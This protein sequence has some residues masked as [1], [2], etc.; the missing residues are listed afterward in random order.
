MRSRI[1]AILAAL[2]AIAFTIAACTFQPIAPSRQSS[3][4]TVAKISLGKIPNTLSTIEADAEDIIDF[5][6]QGDWTRI[7]KDIAEMQSAWQLYLPQASQAAA[8]QALQA[9]MNTAL[10]QL[11]TAAQAQ[12]AAATMQAAND[13]SAA[14]VELFALYDSAIPADIGRLDVLGRQILLDVAQGDW[15]KAEQSLAQTAAVWQR[16]RPSA[17]AQQGDKVVA[18]YDASLSAQAAWLKT[19]DREKLIDEANTGL[20]I[21]DE[22]EGIY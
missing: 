17:L 4:G 9:A 6:P 3:V 21:V 12:D 22:L 15:A 13:V 14:V 2:L 5:A 20:E 11:Q 16:V 10:Q 1:I 18:A 8:P 19:K 7:P